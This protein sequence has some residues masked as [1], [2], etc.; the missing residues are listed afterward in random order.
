MGKHV[1][2]KSQMFNTLRNELFVQY[3]Y[4]DGCRNIG[5]LERKISWELREILGNQ[6]KFPLKLNIYE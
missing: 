1:Q 2:I 6:I 3:Y 4:E 5:V